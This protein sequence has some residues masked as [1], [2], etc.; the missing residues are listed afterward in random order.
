[1]PRIA[2][3]VAEGYPHHITQ[4]GNYKQTVFENDQDHEFYLRR[5]NEYLV[6]YHLSVLAYCLMPNHA[7]FVAVPEKKDS[8][9]KTFNAAH[10]RYAHYYNK[11]NRL[12]G[13]LWQGRFYSCILDS[14]HLFAAVRY[15]E[16]NPVRA[17]LVK[18]AW[19]WKWSS[20]G[21]HVGEEGE[22]I[23]SLADAD[24]FLE[25][26]DWKSYLLQEDDERVITTI[27]KNTMTGRPAGE[28]EFIDKLERMFGRR[29][30]ALR[31]GRPR[32]R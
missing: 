22:G 23:L 31:R 21:E 20:A 32:K 13:H 9:A 30:K 16:N 19:D 8:L 4:R 26:D 15:I 7:H 2:R 12:V 18:K 1:M 24:R 25:I 10:M 11:K 5:L 27:K 6:K 17:N 3:V 29:L 28:N 14:G